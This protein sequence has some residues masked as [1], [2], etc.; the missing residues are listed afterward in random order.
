[1]HEI[2]MQALF[3]DFRIVI[4]CYPYAAMNRFYNAFIL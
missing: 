4:A 3:Y 1:M 2:L